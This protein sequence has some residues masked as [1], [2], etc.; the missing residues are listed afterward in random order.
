MRLTVE[1]VRI[2]RRLFGQLFWIDR[3]KGEQR[4]WSPRRE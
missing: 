4:L 3:V 1:I 2:D